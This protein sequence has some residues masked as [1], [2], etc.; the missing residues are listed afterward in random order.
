MRFY[1][2]STVFLLRSDNNWCLLKPITTSQG[3]YCYFCNALPERK[4]RRTIKAKGE[5][6]GCSFM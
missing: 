5:D 4:R 1:I 6:D 2:S 3:V